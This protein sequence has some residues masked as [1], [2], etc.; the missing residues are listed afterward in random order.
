MRFAADSEPCS[1]SVS[2][3]ESESVALDA[4]DVAAVASPAAV[5]CASFC[6]VTHTDGRCEKT[7]PLDLVI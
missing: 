6:R 2:F 1:V 5:R 7:V 4:A 3:H